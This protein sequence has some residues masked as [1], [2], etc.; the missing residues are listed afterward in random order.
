[1][2]T[3]LE[4]K[5]LRKKRMKRTLTLVTFILALCTLLAVSAFADE[6]V[7]VTALAA[8]GG[9]SDLIETIFSSFTTVIKGLASGLKEA[10]SHVLYEDPTA[11]TPV[12]SPLVLFLFTLAGLGLATGILYKMFGL[13]QA[14]RRG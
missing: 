8:G 10:F 4:K 14:H 3:Q 1:M 2:T 12:F 6:A 11:T 7:P 9:M 5:H 13:I